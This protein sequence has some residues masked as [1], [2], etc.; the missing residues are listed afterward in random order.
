[1]YLLFAEIIRRGERKRGERE[2]IRTE[3][4]KDKRV[5][6]TLRVR[7]WLRERA[8]EWQRAGEREEREK[9][10]RE[11]REREGEIERESMCL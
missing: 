4:E 8:R 10:E 6:E 3:K 2:G 1:V 7:G 9:R 5:W 11:R